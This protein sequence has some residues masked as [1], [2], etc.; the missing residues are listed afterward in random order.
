MDYIRQAIERIT[1]KRRSERF[2]SVLGRGLDGILA[3]T[4]CDGVNPS[5][6]AKSFQKAQI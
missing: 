5:A 1:A 2:N 4:G 3:R 6:L